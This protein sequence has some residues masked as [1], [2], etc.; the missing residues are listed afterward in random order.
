MYS[1]P[2]KLAAEFWGTFAVVLASVGAVCADQFVRGSVHAVG[3]GAVGPAPSSWCAWAIALRAYWASP[4]LTDLAF[5][6]MSAAR[7]AHLGRIFQ[8]GGDGRVLGYWALRARLTRFVLLRGA[9]RRSHS[10]GLSDAICVIPE[11]TWRAKW[12]GTPDMA[13]G[14]TRSSAMLIEGFGTFV[15]AF[16]D[17]SYHGGSYCKE[18]RSAASVGS[19]GLLAPLAGGAPLLR[20]RFSPLRSQAGR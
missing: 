8:S 18:C 14:L 3:L 15:V 9:T 16:C 20:A 17:L 5:A 1:K 19:G 10:G 6:G 13:G 12:L 2:Q 7:G 11:A 4:S